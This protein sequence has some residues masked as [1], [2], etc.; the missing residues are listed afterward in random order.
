MQLLKKLWFNKKRPKIL[1]VN[2]PY[3]RLRGMRSA[4][5]PMGIIYIASNLHACGFEVKVL[6]LEEETPGEE[7]KDGYVN[8]FESYS[9]YTRNKENHAHPAWREFED[10]LNAFEPDI[11]GFSVMT[12]I[13]SLALSMAR[14][15]KKTLDSLVVF[16]GAHPTLCPE[17]AAAAEPVDAVIVGEGEEAFL[18]LATEFEK[19]KK[20]FLSK[21]P[22][23]VYDDGGT[24]VTNPLNPLITDLDSLPMPDYDL[25][26]K[27]NPS[28]LRDRFGVII[29]RGCPYRC[30]FCVDHFMW[31]GKT[32][33]RSLDGI[34][35]EIRTLAD[36]YQLRNLFF[37]Q[38]SFLNKPDLSLAVAEG[39]RDTGRDIGWW[40]AA[41][42]DQIHEQSLPLLK[43]SGLHAVIL[44]IESGS[45]RTLASMN[46]KIGIPQIKRAVDLVR[47]HG[48]KC[49]AFFMM[50]LPD[51]TE[52]DVRMTLSFMEELGLDYYSLSVFT[53]LPR[54]PLFDR[55]V[56][57][58]LVTK[59][60][61]WDL[62]DYQSPENYFS[63]AIAQPRFNELLQEATRL[64][65]KLNSGNG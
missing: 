11:V 24:I 31:R 64:V 39:I 41:R 62:F 30:S 33:F 51:E 57:L 34:L 32:R 54:S 4:E 52:E 3:Q 17:E 49:Y 16:G 35:T 7:L 15:T 56:E 48:I 25:L 61:D 60:I 38:D 46:K 47:K 12:P 58:G 37:Q 20:K 44:G 2:P 29:S 36:R 8:A 1:L 45:P 55:C 43:E 59:E 21:V 18:T 10:C 42:V 6:N 23:A 40:C 53:P 22:S 5:L 27:P 19:G 26:V 28:E 13:Y 63:G 65:D 50:G 9:T 14:F